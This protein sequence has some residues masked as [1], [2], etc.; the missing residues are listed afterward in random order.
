VNLQA[1]DITDL[2][3]QVADHVCAFYNGGNDV[4]DIVVDCA[5]QGL[6]AGAGASASATGCPRNET[7]FPAS[8]SRASAFCRS[9]RKTASICAGEP[10][11]AM[12]CSA[13]GRRWSQ[14]RSVAA[15]SASGRL[16]T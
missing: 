10:S 11:P 8:S 1:A 9:P 14:V 12:H 4:D 3:L 6:Q 7:R 13:S 16:E 15:T 5:S 2:A